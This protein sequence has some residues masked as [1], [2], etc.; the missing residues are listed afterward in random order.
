MGEWRIMLAVN[1]H[2]NGVFDGK[3]RAIHIMDSEGC[4][5]SLDCVDREPLCEYY[6]KTNEVKISR[7]KFPY[8]SLMPWVGNWY[9]DQI[10]VDEK[11]GL[12]ILKYLKSLNKLSPDSA[13]GDFWIQQMEDWVP[14]G[15]YIFNYHV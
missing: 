15:N 11:V 14:I 13:E 2:E 4:D 10:S 7:R 9:W 8:K 5:F 1:H 6:E 3:L 12:E